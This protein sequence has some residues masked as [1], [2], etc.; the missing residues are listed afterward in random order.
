ML[1]GAGV[2]VNQ[3]YQHDLTALMWAAGYG[4]IDTVRLLLT[5]GA[6]VS[7]KDDRGKTAGEI[8]AA[9]G[10]KETAALLAGEK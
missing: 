7:F 9:A 6:E 8:A 3:T 2:D 5:R 1:L 4:K 10:H